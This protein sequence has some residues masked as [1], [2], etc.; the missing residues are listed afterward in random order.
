M[1][2]KEEKEKKPLYK[3]WWFWLIIVILLCGLVG[4][5]QTTNTVNNVVENQENIIVESST[6][7]TLKNSKG[8][9]F[10]ETMCEVGETTKTKAEEIDSNL[11]YKSSNKNYS[12]EIKTNKYDEVT[13][14]RLKAL[15]NID[16][17]NFFIAISR[18]EYDGSDRAETFNW[19]HNNLGKNAKVEAGRT[20]ETKI[21]EATFKLIFDTT[22]K[23][24]LEVYANGI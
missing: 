15:S 11:L 22:K 2:E 21:G 9:E 8:K 18:F 6:T 10:F 4:G 3:K 1:V 16:Y 19:I 17:E 5:N 23:P 24:T 13:Y 7:N 12:I 14:I 20:V